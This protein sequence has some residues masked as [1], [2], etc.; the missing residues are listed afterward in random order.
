MKI[1]RA[2]LMEG[3]ETA[4]S[5]IRELNLER[6]KIEEKMK[7][8]DVSIGEYKARKTDLNKAVSAIATVKNGK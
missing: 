6:Q 8:I 3:I 1:A 2:I 5:R 7:L 4:D